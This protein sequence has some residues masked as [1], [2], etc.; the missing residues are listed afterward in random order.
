MDH[1]CKCSFVSQAAEK[2]RPPSGGGEGGG[3]MGQLSAACSFQC[4]QKPP[5]CPWMEP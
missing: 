4:P 2:R 1:P 5:G 3:E